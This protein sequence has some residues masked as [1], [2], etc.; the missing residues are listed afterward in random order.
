M[1]T[2]SSLT[3]L[4]ERLL[5]GLALV[6][7]FAWVRGVPA[8]GPEL[9]EAHQAG[10]RWRREE[11]RARRAPRRIHGEHAT[12]IIVDESS[13]LD[14]IDDLFEDEPDTGDGR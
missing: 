11:K 14:P 1:M 2:G 4:D 7:F 3:V 5:V 8:T 6:H 12:L 10:M 9:H 13:K